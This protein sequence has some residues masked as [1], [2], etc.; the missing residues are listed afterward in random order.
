MGTA[1]DRAPHRT[2]ARGFA[3]SL[4]PPPEFS[5]FSRHVLGAPQDHASHSLARTPR[6]DVPGG[7]I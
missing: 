6:M 4:S 3:R 5:L 2:P 1:R 7:P